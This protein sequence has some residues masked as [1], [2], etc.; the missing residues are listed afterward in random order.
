MSAAAGRRLNPATIRSVVVLPQPEGPS[1]VA[2]SPRDLERNRVDHGDAAVPLGDPFEDAPPSALAMSVR[3]AAAGLTN[4]KRAATEA[5]VGE[6]SSWC[7]VT[8]TGGGNWAAPEPRLA[9]EF[10]H[11]EQYDE[12]HQDRYR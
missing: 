7:P 1:S 9:D 4:P 10:L 11:G 12:H 5:G 3:R 2:S 8:G 6:I